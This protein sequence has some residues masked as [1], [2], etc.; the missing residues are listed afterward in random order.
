MMEAMSGPR[1]SEPK[2]RVLI[3]E[4]EASI[5]RGLADVLRFKGCEVEAANDGKEGL[6]RALEPGW[7]LIVLDIMLP[8]LNGFV[9]CERLREAGCEAPVLML[10]AK[11]DED[12]I[13]RGF[14]AGANDYVTKPFSVREL[15]ARLDALLRRSAPALP[16][17]FRAG[18]LEV[19]PEHG[20]AR[21]QDARFPLT[22]R[23][24][25]ILQVLS[26]EPGRIVSRRGLLRDAWD[27]R[28]VEQLETRTVDMHIAK[29]RKKLGEHGEMIETVRGQ[30]YR[31]CR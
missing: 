27:M 16:A 7:D 4:D 1:A 26:K 3:I 18:A 28:N 22:G 13:V 29:L 24:M 12:D 30:G 8:E 11:G 2:R 5:R 25:R 6:R 19:H 9:V 17:S 14:E 10:T 21:C 15:G 20:E 31:L 23:E